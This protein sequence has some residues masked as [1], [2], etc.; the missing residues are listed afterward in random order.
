MNSSQTSDCASGQGRL[1]YGWV[2]VASCLL[3]SVVLF[4]I[5]YSYGVFFKPLEAEFGWTRA[6]TSGVFAIYMILASLFAIIGGWALDRYG[7]KVVIIIMGIVTGISLFLTSRV[8]YVWQLYLTY[9][10]LLAGGTGA[11]YAVVM[12]TGSRWFQ[13]QR[14]TV[15]AIIGAG[16]GLGTLIMVPIAAQFISAYDWRTSFLALAIIV[17]VL[18]VPAALLLKKEPGEVGAMPDGNREPIGLVERT[19]VGVEAIH[20][21]LAEAFKTRNF[22]FIFAIWFAY[23]FCVHLVMIHVVPR[24]EDL[25]ISAVQAASIVSVIGAVSIPSRVLI[26]RVSDRV[27]R[28]SVGIV[29]ALVIAVA[30]LWLVASTKMWMFYLFAVVFGISYGG[31]DSPI[32]AMIGDLFG[33]HRV[34]AIMGCLAVGWGLGAALGPYLAG[35]IFDLSKSYSLAFLLGALLMVVAAVFIYQLK[36]AVPAGRGRSLPS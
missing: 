28:R 5:R 14:A 30:L 36:V 10:F 6:M 11:T 8:D 27:G 35:L 31:L 33:L 22:W 1:F 24:A 32:A 23:S 16:I 3:V 26:G 15:L 29:C 13:R 21:S 25:G 12:S 19:E 2:V 20:F 34:G 17:W 18:V 4:G 9:S 7:P